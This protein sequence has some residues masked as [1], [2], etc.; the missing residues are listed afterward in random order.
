[1]LIIS[2]LE[3][4]IINLACAHKTGGDNSS[5]PKICFLPVLCCQETHISVSR[6]NHP[7]KL[8]ENMGKTLMCPMIPVQLVV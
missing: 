6:T 5:L 3:K 1:M 4:A 8:F 2:M 7:V